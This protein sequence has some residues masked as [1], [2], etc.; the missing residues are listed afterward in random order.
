MKH[1]THL[2]AVSVEGSAFNDS[3]MVSIDESLKAP[4]AMTAKQFEALRLDL[5][6][7]DRPT[8]KVVNPSTKA[9]I[10]VLGVF[11]R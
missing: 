8:L 3:V 2:L 6:C 4:N 1:R 9:T 10:I 11:S 5:L 7:G